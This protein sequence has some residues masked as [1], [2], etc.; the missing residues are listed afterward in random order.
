MNSSNVT[1]SVMVHSVTHSNEDLILN[2]DIFESFFK[3]GDY[4]QIYDP[5][6]TFTSGFATS[7]TLVLQIKSS[8]FQLVTN[9]RLE[10][11]LTKSV[12]ETL[13]LKPMN[14]RRLSIQKIEVSK[15]CIDFVELSFKKQFISRGNMWRF[16]NALIG[17][18]IYIGQQIVINKIQAQIQEI[19]LKGVTKI[20]G[21][22]AKDT[23]FIFRSRSTRIIWLVQISGEMWAYDENGNMYFDKFLTKFVDPLLDRWK[24]LGVSHSLTVIFYSRTFTFKSKQS[25]DSKIDETSAFKSSND[26]KGYE[27]HYKVVIENSS[28]ADK[29]YFLKTLKREFWEYAKGL[30]WNINGSSND[31]QS[32]LSLPSDSYDGNFLEAINT[33][34]N[35]LDKHYMDR[36]L[37]RTGN[38]I[39]MIS[40]GVGVFKVKPN[41]SQ[42]TKQRMMD[43]GIGIDL[44]SLS[45][46]PLHAVPLFHVDCRYE[47]FDDQFKH[48]NL[49]VLSYSDDHVADF[50]EQPHW[51]NVSFVDCNCDSRFVIVS[52]P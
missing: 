22:I 50:Y 26:K 39:V 52:K 48:H 21:I 44:I 25:T 51:V 3:D 13:N 45:Q 42:I 27:D 5:I 15:G 19:G 1:Y 17:R 8:M 30:N 37:L 28:E 32:I 23:N 43:S 34:L 16:K 31:E 24:S 18:P 36:D 46:P 40:A 11:S 7:Q 2:K 47:C 9:G 38:S 41:I 14:T 35:I 10:I 33:T 49:T 29:S 20:S 6:E 4:V 12:A